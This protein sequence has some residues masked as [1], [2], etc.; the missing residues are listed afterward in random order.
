MVW[1]YTKLGLTDIVGEKN[2]KER[3]NEVIDA[4]DIAAGRVTHGPDEQNPLETLL[5]YL[6]L[7]ERDVRVHARNIDG[8]LQTVKEAKYII[9]LLLKS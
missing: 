6:L 3:C 7:E 5:H 2:D 1:E 9:S 4:L 8:D